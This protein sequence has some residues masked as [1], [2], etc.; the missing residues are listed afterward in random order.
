MRRINES[1]GTNIT[2]Y[3]EW[4]EETDYYKKHIWRRGSHLLQILILPYSSEPFYRCNGPCRTRRPF[5]GFVK[6]VSNRKPGPNDR[7]FAQHQVYS[8]IPIRGRNSFIIF[9]DQF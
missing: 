1:S 6:R 2:I 4:H 3:H 7:W 9:I 8:W 5:F